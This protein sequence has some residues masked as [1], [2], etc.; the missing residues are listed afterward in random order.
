MSLH[1]GGNVRCK[2]SVQILGLAKDKVR[3]A[4]QTA[5]CLLL[6]VRRAGAIRGISE[7]IKRD[8]EA[9]SSLGTHIHTLLTNG[10]SLYPEASR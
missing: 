8:L 10:A 1:A 2:Q 4:Q 3:S 6:A 9:L 7:S 5:D